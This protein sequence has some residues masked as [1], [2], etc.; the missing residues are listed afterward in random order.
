MLLLLQ[1]LWGSSR[2]N[3]MRK[4]KVQYAT[5]KDVARLA[6]TSVATVSYVLNE[7]PNKSISQETADRVLAAAKELHYKKSAIASGLRGKKQSMVYVI[8]P[9]FNNIYYT[10]VCETIENI[11]YENDI[12]P[13]ICDTQE[14][15][16]R[17]KKLIDTAISLRAD[18]IILGPTAKGWENTKMVRE[19]NIPLV[20]IGREFMT[21]DDTSEVYYVG[22]DS[23]QAGYMAGR[24]LV[25]KGHRQIGMID[26]DGESVSAKDRRLGFID[27]V[28][29]IA[30]FTEV[31]RETSSLL[32]VETGYQLTRRVFQDNKPS[33]IFYSY[34]RLAQGGISYLHE[35]DLVIPQDVEV[36]MVGTPV[37]ANIL[38][39]K[40]TTVDQHEDWIGTTAA[41]IMVSL[42]DGDLS[43]PILSEHRHVCHCDMV[44]HNP[45]RGVQR[46]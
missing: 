11:L 28:K 44:T 30:P 43:R 36:I 42:L 33:A 35:M 23:Y 18:G 4:S 19:L 2:R 9:Q 13:I 31:L 37:W 15:A 7:T 22:D 45:G 24:A 20:S 26:W 12:I 40:Y 38:D 3:A 27:A 6:D 8:I 25:K 46:H 29:E 16:Q 10:R 14:N 39:A 41:K 17:E 1:T 32:D 21:D 5:I 34:H